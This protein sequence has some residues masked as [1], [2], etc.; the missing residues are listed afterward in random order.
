MRLLRSLVPGLLLAAT[1]LATP[2]TARAETALT[3]GQPDWQAR[4]KTELRADQI[5]RADCLA[6]DNMEG[7]SINFH[8]TGVPDQGVYELW[9]GAGCNV[10]TNRT[11]DNPTCVKVSNADANDDVVNARVQDL[12]KN[13]QSALNET[14]GTAATCDDPNDD[15]ENK[16]VLWF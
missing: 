12:V 6:G 5:N 1:W 11:G 8:V 3:V 9:A 13:Y 10:S 16:R 15:A 14:A 2:T 4:P 7:A